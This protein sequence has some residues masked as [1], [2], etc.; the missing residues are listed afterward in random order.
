M[1]FT[2][3]LTRPHLTVPVSLTESI[4]SGPNGAILKRT[5]KKDKGIYIVEG[6]A[7]LIIKRFK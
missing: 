3:L 2:H 1:L 6:D 5:G 7:Q 4:Q